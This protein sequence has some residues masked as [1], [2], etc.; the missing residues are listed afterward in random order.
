MVRQGVLAHE[1][2]LGQC[3][4]VAFVCSGS[5]ASGKTQ[6]SAASHRDV[7]GSWAWLQKRL[8]HE[9]PGN[10]GKMA[11]LHCSLRVSTAAPAAIISMHSTT[12]A[13]QEC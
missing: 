8:S 6:G 12:V 5:R 10:E 7:E 11:S 2:S 9:Q 13:P 3:R 1:A 4:S